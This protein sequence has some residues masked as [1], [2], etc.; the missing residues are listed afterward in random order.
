VLLDTHPLEEVNIYELNQL[1]S[2][3]LESTFDGIKGPTTNTETPEETLVSFNTA[4]KHIIF[5]DK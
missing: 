4:V 2:L 5:P 3:C 1:K